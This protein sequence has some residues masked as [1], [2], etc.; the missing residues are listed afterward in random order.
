MVKAPSISVTHTLEAKAHINIAYLG[1][2]NI[3]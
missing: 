1:A 3:M 2:Y